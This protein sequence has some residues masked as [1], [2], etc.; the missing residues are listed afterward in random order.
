MVGSDAEVESIMFQGLLLGV[1]IAALP[2]LAQARDVPTVRGPA[3]SPAYAAPRDMTGP[4][5]RTR[6]TKPGPGGLTAAEAPLVGTW[7]IGKDG[8]GAMTCAIHLR[9]PAVI[10]GHEVKVAKTCAGAVDRADDLSAWY[11]NTEGRLA[12]SDPLRKQ[13]YLFHRLGD[14]TWATEGGDFDRVLLTRANQV[15]IS[16]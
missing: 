15:G 3:K 14:G 4:A 12:L 5:A 2:V 6:K 8:E 16:R 9:S 13:V 1:L 7:R 10:G 11:V